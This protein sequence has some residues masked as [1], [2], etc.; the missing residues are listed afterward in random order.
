MIRRV[1]LPFAAAPLALCL[2]AALAFA[3]LA[4]P[5]LEGRV[6]DGANIISAP[7]RAALETKLK[8]FEDKSGIQLVVATVTSLQGQ[9]IETYA[10]GLFRQW[11]SGRRPRTTACC[12]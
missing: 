9:D 10:N 12:C 2:L 5:P 4:L 1:V 6:N 8:N 7:M 11:H 3:A